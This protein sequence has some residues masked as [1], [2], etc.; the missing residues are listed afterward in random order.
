MMIVDFFPAGFSTSK[1]QH[2]SD[3]FHYSTKKR[4]NNLTYFVTF[5]FIDHDSINRKKKTIEDCYAFKFAFFIAYFTYKFQFKHRFTMF[6]N[7]F[8]IIINY[9]SYSLWSIILIIV[10]NLSFV[11]IKFV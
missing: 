7:V 3:Y 10:E 5:H 1:P 6:Y 2:P 11:D 9:L 4:Y 8:T